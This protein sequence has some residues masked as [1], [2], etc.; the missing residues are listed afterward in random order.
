MKA[1]RPTVEPAL[2]DGCADRA[3]CPPIA[4][5][6]PVKAIGMPADAMAV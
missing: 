4:H 6:V 3:A 1:E 2:G 5:L